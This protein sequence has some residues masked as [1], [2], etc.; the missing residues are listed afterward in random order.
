MLKCRVCNTKINNNFLSLGKA[1]LSNSYLSYEN[2]DKAE[3]FFPLDLYFCPKCFLVQIVAYEKIENIFS[4][5]YAYHSSYSKSWLDH[6]KKYTNSIIEKFSLN[7]NS[8]VMEI[9]SNDGYLLQYFKEKNIPCL[10][11]EPAEGVAKVAIEKG[12]T[13]DITFFNAT[14]SKNLSKKPDLMIAY[15]VLA[16]NPKLDDFVKGFKLGLNDTGVITMEFPHLLQLIKNN[17]FDTIYHEHYSYFSLNSAKYLFEK[18][19]LEIFDVEELETHG[20]SLR[21]YIKHKN[22]LSKKISESVEMLIKKE[23]EFGLTNSDFYLEFKNKVEKVKRDLLKTLIELKNQNKKIVGYGAPAKGNTLL[24]YCGIRTDF[25]EYTV[26]LNPNKQNKFLPSTNI[27]I[28]S[29][30]KIAEDK[31]DYILILPWNIKEEIIKQLFYV[32]EWGGKFIVP[33][34]S[35]EIL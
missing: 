14:Y 8:F 13:T 17:Q 18:H 33:I 32:K 4:A 6:C 31:P 26:D 16:H 25:I 35:L 19:D 23:V 3:I 22:D 34:P 10:G 5:D 21:L 29:P 2:L 28:F 24:N 15:N 7:E 12:I 1:P 27:P 9:A 11:V 20:G 30:E